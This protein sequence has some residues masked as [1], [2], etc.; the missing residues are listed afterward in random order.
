MNGRFWRLLSIAGWAIGLGCAA[1]PASASTVTYDVVFSS[2]GFHQYSQIGSATP[3]A[4]ADIALGQFHLTMDPTAPTGGSIALDFLS[5]ISLG[6]P[7]GYIY[8]PGTDVLKVGGTDSSIDHGI[9][10]LSA[11]TNDILVTIANFTSGN[12]TLAQVAYSSTGSA[13]GFYL[14]NSGIVH[15]AQSA[16]SSPPVAT[17]PIPATLPLFASALGGLG[18]AGWRRRKAAT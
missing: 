18:F 17:T 8:D 14:S 1:V 4:P 15:V 13:I 12:P 11:T 5:N 10:H 6:S 9:T 7:L 16:A 3:P 2:I